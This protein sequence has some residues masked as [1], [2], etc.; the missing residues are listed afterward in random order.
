MCIRDSWWITPGWDIAANYTYADVEVTKDSGNGLQ[1][2]TP[3]YVPQHSATLWST[4][5]IESGAL[6]GATIAGGARYLGEMY[7]DASNT[8]GK[9]PGYTIAD[10]TL[11]YQLGKVSD[12]L[13]GARA[14]LIVSNLFNEESYTCYDRANCWYGAE[15]TIEFNVNYQF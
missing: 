11:G 3:I 1:G 4:Y 7:M 15:R 8:Q 5:H 2:T 13:D 14:D 12:S 9:V 6:N 10:L